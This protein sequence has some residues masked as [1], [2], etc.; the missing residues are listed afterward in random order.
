LRHGKFLK[1][2][3]AKSPEKYDEKVFFNCGSCVVE[4]EALIME[5]ARIKVSSILQKSWQFLMSLNPHIA[6]KPYQF[7]FRYGT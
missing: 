1:D 6:S 2:L 4:S 5:V 7:F 3:F